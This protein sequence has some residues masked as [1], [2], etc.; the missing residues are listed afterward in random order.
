M[1]LL[2]PVEWRKLPVRNIQSATISVSAALDTIYDMLTG[3]VYYNGAERVV[4]S[5]SAW[6]ASGKFATGS[7]T[8]AIWC[9]P[10]TLTSISQS[11]IFAGKNASGPVS[12]AVAPSMLNDSAPST[13]V[14]TVHMAFVKNATGSFTQW[15]SQFPFGSSSYSTGFVRSAAALNANMFG[16]KFVIYESK[17]AIAFMHYYTSVPCVVA[18][19]AG[20]II[21]PEQSLPTSS[22]DAEADGRLYGLVGSSIPQ[23]TPTPAAVTS[24]FLSANNSDSSFLSY[25]ANAPAAT[26]AVGKFGVFLP[27]TNTLYGIST[28]KL[29]T[30]AMITYRTLSGKLVT[31]PLK[32]YISTAGSQ[33]FPFYMGRLRDI[34]IATKVPF[35][36]ILTDFDGTLIGYALS[37][38]EVTS[39]DT[40][41]FRHQ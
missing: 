11:I 9:Y 5:G 10:P 35:D 15:T 33:T 13:T 21:D 12:T 36:N 7:N 20:A 1:A 3:S 22:F 26:S 23:N 31:S 14:P 39:G 37:F 32:C 2:P 25:S 28:D 38:S 6:S 17:E 24:N 16:S 34:S 41:I 18:T 4:G 30:D 29:R 8:E 40:V 19:I 27:N